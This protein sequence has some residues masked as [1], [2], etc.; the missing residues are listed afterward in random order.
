MDTFLRR[1]SSLLTVISFCIAG[2][3]WQASSEQLHMYKNLLFYKEHTELQTIAPLEE[4][5][6]FD[7]LF[8][9]TAMYNLGSLDSQ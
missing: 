4:R 5:R 1:W 6:P 9:L 8:A 3:K 2:N 7:Q